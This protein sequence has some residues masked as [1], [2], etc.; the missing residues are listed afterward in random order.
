[1]K[2]AIIGAGKIGVALAR[3]FAQRTSKPALL[4]LA[5]PKR[6]LLSKPS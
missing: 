3:K 4:T 2:H 5:G 6:L 1:M